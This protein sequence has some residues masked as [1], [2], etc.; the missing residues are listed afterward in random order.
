MSYKNN[1]NSTYKD[2]ANKSGLF[3]SPISI[4]LGAKNTGVYFAHYKAG[5]SVGD[6][7]KPKGKVYQLDDKSYTLLMVNRTAKTTS[8]AWL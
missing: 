1:K 6:E 8:K 4:D 5:S 3:I 2:T 7:L